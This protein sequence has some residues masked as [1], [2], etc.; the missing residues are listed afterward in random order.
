VN[1]S[2][3]TLSYQELLDENQLLNEE[4]K[5][6][7]HAAE[8]TAELVVREIRRME[9]V[10]QELEEKNLALKSALLEIE[11]LREILPICA[12]CKSIRNDEGHWQPVEVYFMEN[13]SSELTHGICPDCEEAMYGKTDWYRK[14]KEKRARKA[15]EV[16]KDLG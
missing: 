5:V 15:A 11:T 3:T 4:V 12:R 13:S 6:S 10:R 9:E 7:R 8:L 1:Q 2:K 14:L 16:V